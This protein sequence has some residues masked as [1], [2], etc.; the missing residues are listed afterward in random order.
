MHAL[1]LRNTSFF[2]IVNRVFRIGRPRSCKR[3]SG[4]NE[5]LETVKGAPSS[6]ESNMGEEWAKEIEI[7][8]ELDGNVATEGW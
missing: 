6:I 2:P 4:V 8:R 7:P 3:K 1:K 5:V